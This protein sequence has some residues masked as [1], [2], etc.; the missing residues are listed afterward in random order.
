[1]LRRTPG[2]RMYFGARCAQ[3]TPEEYRGAKG[4]LIM[5]GSKMESFCGRARLLIQLSRQ[6]AGTKVLNHEKH[7]KSS[8]SFRSGGNVANPLTTFRT[9]CNR[10]KIPRLNNYVFSDGYPV[11]MVGY[12]PGA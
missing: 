4:D 8:G 12:R 11:W 5:V 1:M 2:V 10:G 3:L 6:R 7:S 9:E